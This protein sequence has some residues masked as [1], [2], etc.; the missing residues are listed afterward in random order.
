MTEH[1]TVLKNES[2]DLLKLKENGVYI[3]AT[4]GG[5]GHSLEILKGLNDVTL[6]C[7]DLDKNNIQEFQNVLKEEGIKFSELTLENP[8]KSNESKF[9]YL[10]NDNFSRLNE[11]IS[12]IGLSGVDGVLADLG[13]S[14][15]QLEK[16]PGLS[17][18]DQFEELDMR[19]SSDF[20][21]KAKDLLNALSK[22]E[23]SRMFEE[24]SDIRGFQN[25]KLVSSIISFRKGNLF[26]TVGDLI[27]VI[28]S[29]SRNS[30][31]QRSFGD[32]RNSD[33]A[34][35]FQSL[36]IAVNSEM[37]NLK[38]LLNNGWNALKNGGNFAVITFHSGEEKVVKNFFK[39]YIESNQAV[40][41][42]TQY[43]EVYTRPSVEELTENLKSRS[44]KLWSVEKQ[45]LS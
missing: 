9:V 12:A 20:G 42:S 45:E 31:N 32:R 1:K 27:K 3:D 23:L 37:N 25:Q 36:R 41:N 15:D 11:Y 24:Y 38:D 14:S 29:S 33:Y 17:F 16:I 8:E 28:D 34:R 13:W 35:V 30:N 6:I 26:E 7:F 43:G 10:V 22:K 5:G 4:L 21:V 2:I 19:L 40:F 44:A 18:Q 39:K